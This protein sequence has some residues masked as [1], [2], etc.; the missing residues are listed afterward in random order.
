M[1]SSI[2]LTG[3]E[4]YKDDEQNYPESLIDQLAL[5][6]FELTNMIKVP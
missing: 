3:T 6:C 2:S 1:K 4:G 5:Q